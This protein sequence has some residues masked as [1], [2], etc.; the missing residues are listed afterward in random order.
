MEH[1]PSWEANRF[2][3]SQKIPHILWNPKVHYR[4]RKCPPPLPI[5]LAEHSDNYIFIIPKT[6]V[7]FWKIIFWHLKGGYKLD[8]SESA[9]LSRYSHNWQLLERF[10]T[11]G[12]P[13][14]YTNNNG[15]IRTENHNYICNKLLS[16]I[17]YRT[18]YIAVT[19]LIYPVIGD[20]KMQHC[21]VCCVTPKNWIQYVTF[22]MYNTLSSM[23]RL[24]KCIC[25]SINT[26]IN[27]QKAVR[28][29]I[30]NLYHKV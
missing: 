16:N 24:S 7:N 4:I 2:S 20:F 13:L 25:L 30:Y 15:G 5:T 26:L 14:W 29:C 28:Y 19:V 11:W 3:A 23:L 10:F 22:V 21:S 6:Y 8:P 27:V 9:V 17:M 12:M 1:T 18:Y